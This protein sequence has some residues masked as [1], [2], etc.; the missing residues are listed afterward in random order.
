MCK[1]SHYLKK[2]KDKKTN[3]KKMKVKRV[4]YREKLIQA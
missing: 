4:L 2:K 1:V 3:N